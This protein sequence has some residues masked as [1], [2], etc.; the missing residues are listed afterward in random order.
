MRFGLIHRIMTDA[1]AALGLLSLLASGELNRW[2]VIVTLVG[3]VVAVLLPQ[4]YQDGA[5]VRRLAVV[6]PLSLLAL[7]TSR[8][9]SGETLLPLAVE[10]AAALQVVRLATRRGAAHDQQVIV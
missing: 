5:L 6:V 9:F 8:L 3:L 7:Q 2:F 1:L 4:R 10:F